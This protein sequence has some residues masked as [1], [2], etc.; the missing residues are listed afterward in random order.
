MQAMSAIPLTQ[1]KLLPHRKSLRL[2]KAELTANRRMSF[3]RYNFYD[4]CDNEL[5]YQHFHDN[6]SSQNTE[7]TYSSLLY[8][9]CKQIGGDETLDQPQTQK[10]KRIFKKIS[11]H[12]GLTARD[13]NYP[14]TSLL[15]QLH[16]TA[17]S[18][19]DTSKTSTGRTAA[20]NTRS[21]KKSND[22]NRINSK[23]IGLQLKSL[24]SSLSYP[25]GSDLVVSN[26]ENS[27]NVYSRRLQDVITIEALRKIVMVPSELVQDETK[28]NVDMSLGEVL[29]SL[30][31]SSEQSGQAISP[32]Y[33][34]SSLML[35]MCSMLEEDNETS[36]ITSASE[37]LQ[38]SACNTSDSW[39]DSE[40]SSSY[41]SLDSYEDGSSNKKKRK[42]KQCKKSSKFRSSFGNIEQND[43][44]PKICNETNAPTLLKLLLADIEP[45][46]NDK[47]NCKVKVS[48]LV[49]SAEDAENDGASLLKNFLCK[50]SNEFKEYYSRIRNEN[51]N[52]P[53]NKR[54]L[55]CDN[56]HNV[57]KPNKDQCQSPNIPDLIPCALLATSAMSTNSRVVGNPEDIASVDSENQS[58]FETLENSPPADTACFSSSSFP[59]ES[60]SVSSMFCQLELG[61]DVSCQPN[62]TPDEGLPSLPQHHQYS[63]ADDHKCGLCRLPF[64]SSIDL[65]CHRVLFHNDREKLRD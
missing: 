23:C 43:Q 36:D 17:A 61:A 32:E 9:L 52:F 20:S 63:M 28:V 40:S 41:R 38:G 5:N 29:S 13:L 46:T 16:R 19:S 26:A 54:A 47:M 65:Q 45:M 6:L 58:T 50:P 25:T 51:P 11:L 35:R 49:H 55:K 27:Q 34:F 1:S 60:L 42:R 15:C 3:R 31:S 7:F 10:N 30:G 33:M 8:K 59:S 53:I 39:T 2:Q 12:E 56:V 14:Y 62:E 4:V 18:D 21:C 57:G 22:A 37:D 24:L 44:Y 64:S 48:P